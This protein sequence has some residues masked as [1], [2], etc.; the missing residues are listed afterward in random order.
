[1]DRDT[2]CFY[3]KKKMVRTVVLALLGVIVILIVAA[4]VR[5]R[6]KETA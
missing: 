3:W 4:L 1:M 5:H 2:M 6:D